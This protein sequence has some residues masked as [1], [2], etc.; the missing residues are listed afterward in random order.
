MPKLK[1][2]T[3][4]KPYA[5]NQGTFTLEGETVAEVLDEIV[6][7]HPQLQKHLFTDDGTLRPFVNLFLGEE[8]V[9][10]LDG[11]KTELS[12]DDTILIIP[13]IAGG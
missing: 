6:L 5:G 2:P 12:A 3:P 7:L 13:S 1:L 11:L 10:H 9:N 4:L 8:N